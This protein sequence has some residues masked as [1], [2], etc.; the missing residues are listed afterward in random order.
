MLDYAL[1]TSVQV[2]AQSSKQF[3]LISA[4]EKLL[5]QWNICDPDASLPM[6]HVGE[7]RSALKMLSTQ[8]P[9]APR[10][11]EP[12]LVEKTPEN[13]SDLTKTTKTKLRAALL[14]RYFNRFHPLNGLKSPRKVYGTRGD[15]NGNNM[16]LKSHLKYS[17]VYEICLILHPGFRG[18]KLVTKLVKD[19]ELSD[20][21]FKTFPLHAKFMTGDRTPDLKAIRDQFAQILEAV[22]E[23]EIVELATIY[24]TYLE[25]PE[26]QSQKDSCVEDCS[27]M[28]KRQKSSL[29]VFFDEDEDGMNSSSDDS[30]ENPRSPGD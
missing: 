15:S 18:E 14:K 2:T 20:D 9:S 8:P 4:Y 25:Q 6:V 13:L 22:L 1:M 3:A 10:T 28:P 12:P 27:P 7:A 5:D 19:I 29:D 23:Y 11:H 24:Y 26:L 30:D 17:Y 16:T 21:E